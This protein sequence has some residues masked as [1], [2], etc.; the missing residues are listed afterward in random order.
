[1]GGRNYLGGTT[2]W[3]REGVAQYL[4]KS[5]LEIFV[6]ELTLFRVIPQQ[7]PRW[8]CTMAT[9]EIIPCIPFSGAERGIL[10]DFGAWNARFTLHVPPCSLSNRATLWMNKWWIL[11]W[12]LPALTQNSVNLGPMKVSILSLYPEYFSSPIECGLLRRA[13]N[14]GHVQV[15]IEDIRNFAGDKHR[16]VDDRPFG[17]GAGMVMKPEP[18]CRAID[19]VRSNQSHV[20][21]FSP[22][23]VRMTAARCRHWAKKQHV[24]LLCGHFEGVDERVID[25]M[26]DEEVSIGDYVLMSGCPAALVWIDGVL[27]FVPGV[28]GS[29]ESFEND[30]FERDGFLDHPHYTR[31]SS[32]P[33]GGQERCVP[34]VLLSGHHGNIEMWRR[35]K[36]REKTL[37]WKKQNE[38]E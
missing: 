22:Q 23:G 29:E 21:Y 35:E 36:S 32:F 19:A 1:M 12:F 38:R 27:R 10:L 31:P 2:S 11:T 15:E 30:S 6:G 33:W 4:S 17:G 14:R 3:S 34:E 13:S 20:I 5:L 26:V 16:T 37:L 9:A 25:L 7:W 18:I 24:V 28:L 8:E